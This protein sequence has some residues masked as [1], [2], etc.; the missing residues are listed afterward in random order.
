VPNIPHYFQR[1]HREN[2]LLDALLTVFIIHQL[3]V[4][5]WRGLWEAVNFYL[6]PDDP[7]LSGVITIAIS[8]VLQALVCIAEPTVNAKYRRNC[9]HLTTTS[10][11]D[12][13]S[14]DNRQLDVA[15]VW[16]WV[17]ETLFYFVGNLVSVLHWRG[18]W[19]LM[20]NHVLPTIPTMSG[21]IT[22]VV[23][24]VGLWLMLAGNSVTQVGC[25]LDG[26]SWP[27]DGCTMPNRYIRYFISELRQRRRQ[28]SPQ[29]NSDS[30]TVSDNKVIVFDTF[31]DQ[32]SDSVSDT[33]SSSSNNN[34]RCIKTKKTNEKV[35]RLDVCETDDTLI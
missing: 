14:V 1:R 13:S 5:F 28:R 15:R 21:V 2:F 23:G 11:A 24:I 3:V 12:S 27:E 16:C 32:N 4:A 31:N 35:E 10:R 26:N 29:Y 9:E 17:L 22:H 20:D 6:I 7:T 33:S 34:S 19:I 25:L 8:Y 30:K 18:F